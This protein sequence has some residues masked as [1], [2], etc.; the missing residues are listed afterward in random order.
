[1]ALIDR[2]ELRND[3]PLSSS[4]SRSSVISVFAWRISYENGVS[5]HSLNAQCDENFAIDIHR[6]DG[7]GMINGPC[8]IRL[9][10]IVCSANSSLVCNSSHIPIIIAKLT[11]SVSVTVRLSKLNCRPLSSRRRVYRS[12]VFVPQMPS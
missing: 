5:M 9:P 4:R 10:Y 3:K 7:D 11:I 12:Y 6:A 8:A 1:M 2:F